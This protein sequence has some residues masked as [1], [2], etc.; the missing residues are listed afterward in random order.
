M[1]QVNNSTKIS[2]ENIAKRLRP[3]IEDTGL[4]VYQDPDGS[5]D[6]V[7]LYTKN[8]LFWKQHPD[9]TDVDVD[10]G[11]VFLWTDNADNKAQVIFYKDSKY[12]DIDNAL[13]GYVPESWLYTNDFR[14]F[15]KIAAGTRNRQS[16][17]ALA[18]DFSNIE[19]LLTLAML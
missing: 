12:G 8:E 10:P 13:S 6:C 4:I 3:F 11:T 17:R 15:C 7:G 19:H 9:D 2:A 16:R 18:F 5:R 14:E 1:T